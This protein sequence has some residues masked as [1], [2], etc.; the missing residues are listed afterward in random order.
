MYLCGV[1]LG[2]G[3]KGRWPRVKAARRAATICRPCQNCLPP[4]PYGVQGWGLG[5]LALKWRVGRLT[6]R[7]GSTAGG[8]KERPR[9]HSFGA[10]FYRLT[11][12]KAGRAGSAELPL[13]DGRGHLIRHPCLSEYRHCAGIR[14]ASTLGQPGTGRRLTGVYPGL[15]GR[16][17]SRKSR[18]LP[19]PT[20]QFC[21][22]SIRSRA[23]E[24][25]R[26][27]IIAMKGCWRGP[28]NQQGGDL[29]MSNL[30]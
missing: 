25:R 10:W 21:W 20:R 4:C 8:R 18:M 9:L 17:Y 26:A 27:P 19:E 28:V 23:E 14:S 29:G 2:N 12:P 5:C 30:V 6:N 24:N 1:P 11:V 16:A 3:G 13:T 7:F 22:R 15:P